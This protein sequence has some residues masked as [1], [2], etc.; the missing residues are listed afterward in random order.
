MWN[1][2]LIAALDKS[3][4]DLYSFGDFIRYKRHCKS[5]LLLNQERI[6]CKHRQIE[7]INCIFNFHLLASA[8]K[9]IEFLYYSLS[10]LGSFSFMLWC[11]LGTKLPYR[12][13]ELAQLMHHS[14]SK[15]CK[16]SAEEPTELWT[17]NVK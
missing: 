3:C 15:M 1:I 10:K 14:N 11:L 5:K 6:F 16:F 2:I 8:V 4:I 17:T 13:H 12:L 9:D 7:Q